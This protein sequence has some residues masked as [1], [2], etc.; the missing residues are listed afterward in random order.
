MSV[1]IPSAKEILSTGLQFGHSV[2]R[3][4]PRM[5]KYIWGEKNG[6]HVV[7]IAQTQA[8]LKEA[9][10]FLTKVAATGEVVFVGTKR[11][12]ASLVKEHA[13][14]AGAHFIVDRWPGGMLTNFKMSQRSLHRLLELEKMFEEGV[15]GRTKYEVSR[16]KVEWQRL[17]RLYGGI[18]KLTAKPVAVVVI[19]PKFEIVAVRECR[20][21]NLPLI[22]LADTNCDPAMLDY[23]IPGNDDALKAIEMVISVLADAVLEGNAGKGVKHEL[24]DYSEVEVKMRKVS[25]VEAPE[26][27]SIE[28]ADEKPVV[29]TAQPGAKPVRKPSKSAGKGILELAKEQAV[30]GDDKASATKKA[31]AA[32]KSSKAKPAKK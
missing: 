16:M 22:A 14:R 30:A 31:P 32:K 27:V 13:M 20:R 9:A 18:K 4:N 8:A 12:A 2:S 21:L 26:L 3:W 6:I 23:C 17:D 11:Q 19:D 10:D 15:E 24:K 5:S 25:E 1:K 28:T 7:D 29:V